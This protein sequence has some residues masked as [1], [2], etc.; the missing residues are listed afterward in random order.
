MEL[1]VPFLSLISAWGVQDRW[2]NVH[3]EV[4]SYKEFASHVDGIDAVIGEC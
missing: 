3:L 2:L 1:I 4:S